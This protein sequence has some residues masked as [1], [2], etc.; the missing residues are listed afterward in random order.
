M[1]QPRRG[2]SIPLSWNTSRPRS[3]YTRLPTLAV[4]SRNCNNQG[5]LWTGTKISVKVINR[6]NDITETLALTSWK[7]PRIL[8]QASCWRAIARRNTI[9]KPTKTKVH[10]RNML[11]IPL[12]SENNNWATMIFWYR[13]TRSI[14][15]TWWR[16][17]DNNHLRKRRDQTMWT[18]EARTSSNISRAATIM[19][20]PRSR[21]DTTH[22]MKG[23]AAK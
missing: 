1:R 2:P 4:A 5:A 11:I 8:R 23:T 3:K 6:T 10:S 16:K 20:K 15:R 9:W 13:R 7:T 19:D 14:K 12:S 21:T 22:T 18:E 17:S